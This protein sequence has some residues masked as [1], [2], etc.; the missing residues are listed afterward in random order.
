M[1]PELLSHDNDVSSCK[2]TAS[3]VYSLG[4]TFLEV[5]TGKPPLYQI[6][7]DYKVIIE[8]TKGSDRSILCAQMEEKWG[9]ICGISPNNTGLKTQ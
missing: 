8:V 6:S 9:Q 4:C 5:Y 3:D 1:A 2:T 7:N